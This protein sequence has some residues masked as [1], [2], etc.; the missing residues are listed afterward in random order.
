MAAP[1]QNM[2]SGDLFIPHSGKYTDT[3]QNLESTRDFEVAPFQGTR[4]SDAA[5]AFYA[6]YY[7]HSVQLWHTETSSTNQ[8]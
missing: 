4:L 7:N 2:Y 5:Y 6:A 1:L 3:W 8:F